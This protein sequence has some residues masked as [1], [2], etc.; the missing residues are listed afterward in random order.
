M[1]WQAR[2]VHIHTRTHVPDWRWGGGLTGHPKRELMHVGCAGKLTLAGTSPFL[3]CA[4]Q[5]Y[6]IHNYSLSNAT[7][8]RVQIK[9]AMPSFS[10]YINHHEVLAYTTS[11]RSLHLVEFL[12]GHAFLY[13]LTKSQPVAN[14]TDVSRLGQ[15]LGCWHG[16]IRSHALDSLESTAR[17]LAGAAESRG[18]GAK[19]KANLTRLLSWCR[20]PCCLSPWILCCRCFPEELSAFREG[21]G[22]LDMSNMLE[23]AADAAEGL[24]E[25]IRPMVDISRPEPEQREAEVDLSGQFTA[26]ADPQAES[27]AMELINSQVDGVK[28]M[29][30]TT[31]TDMMNN[32]VPSRAFA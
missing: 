5:L 22:N 19:G 10:N 32:F 14:S 31:A 11:V 8:L 28:S 26:L 23:A 30:M 24:A 3:Q 4:L 20:I 6:E 13:L 17:P 7:S 21:F 27:I 16:G 1:R 2:A 29:L 15:S 12:H 25:L 9:Y 18:S